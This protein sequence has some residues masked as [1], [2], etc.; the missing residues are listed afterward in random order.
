M[1]K[2][3][4]K[5]ILK[6]IEPLVEIKGTGYFVNKIVSD[7]YKQLKQSMTK[8]KDKKITEIY[9]VDE[10]ARAHFE[11]EKMKAEG[12]RGT[13]SFVRGKRSADI[14]IKIVYEK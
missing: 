13:L 1:T 2:K 11:M 5:K 8:N 3:K 9:E 6:T 7:K 12:Y 10:A 14:K 4:E